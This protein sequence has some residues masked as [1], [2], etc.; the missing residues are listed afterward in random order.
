M[1]TSHLLAHIPLWPKTVI[2]SVS[3]ISIGT[4]E[5]RIAASTALSVSEGASLGGKDLN[6]ILSG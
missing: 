5:R 1:I 4:L 6:M 3:L 2:C